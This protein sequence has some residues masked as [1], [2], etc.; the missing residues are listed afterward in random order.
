MNI[1][2]GITQVY[3]SAV[4]VIED[5]VE[6]VGRL[7]R[8]MQPDEERMTHVTNQ[9]VPLCHDVLHLVLLDYLRLIEHLDGVKGV[10]VLVTG[11]QHLDAEL[12]E[13]CMTPQ[14]SITGASPYLEHVRCDH[15]GH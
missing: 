12:D 13:Y 6:F 7:E 2:D 11:K 1:H 15:I 3:L 9:H 4:D 10:L 5:E 8:I 14:T